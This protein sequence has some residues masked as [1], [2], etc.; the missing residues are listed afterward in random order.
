MTTLGTAKA[1][2][3]HI[4][5][6]EQFAS[7]LALL[8][9]MSL[10]SP[11]SK[12]REQQILESLKAIGPRYVEAILT[13]ATDRTPKNALAIYEAAKAART[14]IEQGTSANDAEPAF[15][16]Q[17]PIPERADQIKGYRT[18]YAGAIFNGIFATFAGSTLFDEYMKHY[19]NFESNDIKPDMTRLLRQTSLP[20]RRKSGSA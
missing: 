17:T 3:I 16:N 1:N 13:Y 7:E 2:V 19:N 12:D 8:K 14:L 18:P 11:R 15:K 6:R 20:A 4:T 9:D 5:G 10:G